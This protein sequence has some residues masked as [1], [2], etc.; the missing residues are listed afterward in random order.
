MRP[1]GVH[2]GGR[3]GLREQDTQRRPYAEFFGYFLVQRQESNVG[4]RE[5]TDAFELLCYWFNDRKTVPFFRDD[6]GD[7]VPDL[8]FFDAAVDLREP[9][10]VKS[11]E[12]TAP[13]DFLCCDK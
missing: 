11:G 7:K 10:V 4:L 5:H 9:E 12:A 1:G 2:R 3:I 8:F 6:A 13:P